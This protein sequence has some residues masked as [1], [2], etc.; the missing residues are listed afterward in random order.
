MDDDI[1]DEIIEYTN[2]KLAEIRVK[3]KNQEKPELRNTDVEEMK[4]IR[5]II[6]LVCLQI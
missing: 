3:Y 6:L 4:A 5:F 1:T 2:K